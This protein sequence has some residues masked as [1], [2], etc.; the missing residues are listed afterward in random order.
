[1]PDH[2][3][4]SRTGNG[5]RRSDTESSSLLSPQR[6][7]SL[8]SRPTL[9]AGTAV[10]V[11]WTLHDA[12]QVPVVLTAPAAAALGV[13]IWWRARRAGR[14]AAAAYQQHGDGNAAVLNALLDQIEHGRKAISDV[15]EQTRRGDLSASR[16]MPHHLPAGLDGEL[17]VAVGQLLALAH[18]EAGQAV[19]AAARDQHRL[20]DAER[21]QMDMVLAIAMRLSSLVGRTLEALEAAERDIEDPDVLR[22][23][24]RI[25]NLVTRVRRQAQGLAVLGGRALTASH[26]PLSVSTV[27]R[28]A[29]EEIEQYPRVKIAP[30]PDLS[31]PGQA[32]PSVVHLLA[33]LVE[34]AAQFSEPATQVLVRASVVPAGLV[35]EVE[36]RGLGIGHGRLAQLN[37]LLTAPDTADPRARLAEGRIGLLVTGRLAQRLGLHVELRPSVL[38]G[39]EALVL[40]PA[41]LLLAPRNPA[42]DAATHSRPEAHGA[43][44]KDVVPTPAAMSGPQ[45]GPVPHP[46]PASPHPPQPLDQAGSEGRI[47]LPRRTR[48]QPQSRGVG[49]VPPA[50]SAPAPAGPTPSLMARFAAGAQE[51]ARRTAGHDG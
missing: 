35:I 18:A 23:L 6:L 43:V 27:L 41:R 32:G 19:L 22:D 49:S 25:D 45:A 8:A 48:P 42:A 29:A 34:N 1:M 40:V 12:G 4:P 44:P 13:G 10:A 51:A 24:F 14:A 15:L 21:A 26:E 38:G 16:S 20:V 47:P 9:A 5:R 7:Q 2:A 36:D 37:Q 39:T 46:S 28:Q 3:L 33:E 11:A 30:A 50:V 17:P 31:L